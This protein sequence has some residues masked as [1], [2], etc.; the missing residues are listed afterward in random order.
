[1]PNSCFEQMLTRAHKFIRLLQDIL[2]VINNH[3]KRTLITRVL[4]VSQTKNDIIRLEKRLQ[5]FVNSYMVSII[6][7]PMLISTLRPLGRNCYANR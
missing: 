1:M 6:Y 2:V 3:S 5:F 4:N 7:Y